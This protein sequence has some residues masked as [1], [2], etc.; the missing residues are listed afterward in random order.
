M[1]PLFQKYF[2]WDKDG[3]NLS[4]W[5]TSNIWAVNNQIIIADLDGDNQVEL[6][7]D[8]N[9]NSGIY[10]GY[11]H[12]GTPMSG[13]PLTV[14]GSSFFMNPFVADVNNDGILGYFRSQCRY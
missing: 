8:D 3:N 7:W 12:D 13:W 9:T 11:N 5:P 10:L 2:V 14:T 6:M 4:G 1:V